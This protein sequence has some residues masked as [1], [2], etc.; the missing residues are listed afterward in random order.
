MRKKPL[1]DKQLRSFGLIVGVGFAVI[2]V[3]P[4]VFRHE[5]PRLWAFA[6]AAPLA[7]LGLVAPST[8]VYPYKVWMALGGALGYV[9]TRIILSVMYFTIF[10]PAGLLMRALGKDPMR[11]KLDPKGETYRVTREPRARTHMTRMF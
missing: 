7:L 3:G 1:D 8:L 5:G 4:M 6:I 11:R 9:N 10:L 2:G